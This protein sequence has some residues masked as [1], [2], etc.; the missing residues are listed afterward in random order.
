MTTT[1]IG[2]QNSSRNGDVS[3]CVVFSLASVNRPLIRE[4][5][6]VS[7]RA[8]CCRQAAFSTPSGRSFCFDEKPHIVR[9]A[10]LP[11]DSLTA[12]AIAAQI[13][14]TVDA[15]QYDVEQLG[16]EHRLPR[17]KP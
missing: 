14:L 1:T 8:D 10:V 4:A 15:T 9:R 2:G 12:A 5:D 11:I 7:R 6:P 3:H 16:Q 17:S 13:A